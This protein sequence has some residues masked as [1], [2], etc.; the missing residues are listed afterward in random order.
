[1]E[2]TQYSSHKKKKK[3]EKKY[4]RNSGESSDNPQNSGYLLV[5]VLIQ[6]ICNE[7]NKQCEWLLAA[8]S[9]P[10]SYSSL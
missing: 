6:A 8:S 2:Y 9:L 10:A 5:D 7:G 3:R 4:L 1:M